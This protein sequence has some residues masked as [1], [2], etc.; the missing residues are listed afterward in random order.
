MVRVQARGAKLQK[1]FK[2]KSECGQYGER[3]GARGQCDAAAGVYG[4]QGCG[5]GYDTR[6]GRRACEGWMEV[7]CALSRAAEV[8]AAIFIRQGSSG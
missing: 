5:A 4:V 7:Q 2:G 1:A 6:V 3:R 8:S